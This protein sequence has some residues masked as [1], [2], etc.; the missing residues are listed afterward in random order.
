MTDDKTI[1]DPVRVYKVI[2]DI[3]S[4][5]ENLKITVN[6]KKKDDCLNKRIA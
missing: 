5:R 3:L 6:V 1:V 2:A 4:R